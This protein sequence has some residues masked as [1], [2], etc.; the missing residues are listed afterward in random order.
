MNQ[1]KES[2]ALRWLVIFAC[3]GAIALLL[4]AT[5]VMIYG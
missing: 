5:R 2:A 1:Q 3:A 4:I